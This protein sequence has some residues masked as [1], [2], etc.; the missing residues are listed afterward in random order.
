M[1]A[2]GVDR[3]QHVGRR[4]FAFAGEALDQL[5]GTTLDHVYLNA[6]FLGELLEQHRVGIVMAM[7]VDS[8]LGSR[9]GGP[10]QQPESEK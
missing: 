9:S 10:G 7:R 3:Q 4:V 8:Q 2:A 6:G 1:Q 5:V